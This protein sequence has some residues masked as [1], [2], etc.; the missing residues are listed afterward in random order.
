MSDSGTEQIK[1]I[2]FKWSGVNSEGKTESGEINAP[3]K[4]AALLMVAKK[5]KN[6]IK[7]KVNNSSSLF[8][9]KIQDKDINIFFRQL[10][11][12]ISTGLPLIQCLEMA[13]AGSE[14][15]TFKD[16]LNKLRKDIESGQPF[17]ETLGKQ[18]E[19]FD[20]LTCALITAGE[21]GGI[22][23]R[24]LVRIADYKERAA[25]LKGKIKSAMIYPS[26]IIATAFAVTSILMI[27]V[28]PVFGKMFSGAGRK[29]PALTQITIDASG[30]FVEYWYVI[31]FG[32]VLLLFLIRSWYKTNRGKHV[33]DAL[34]LKIPVLG[35]VLRKA[36]VARFCRTFATLISAGVP[37]LDAL[38]PVA[39]T[40]GNVII[41]DVLRDSKKTIMEGRNLTDP[42]TESGLFPVMVTQMIDIGEQ[43]GSLEETLSKV[44]DF[45]DQEVSQA[46]D[47][48]TALMEPLIMVVLGTLIGGLVISMY[49]PIFKMAAVMG[50]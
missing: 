7:I 25:I 42:L 4:E 18:P 37:I 29:L 24:I 34:I 49:L 14:N 16:I 11:T 39:E 27:F 10:A 41:E 2:S 20:R 19:Q 44:A 17:A 35:P 40:S 26:A 28:I 22:L 36:A 48:M 9:Q 13:E 38:D 43:T 30:L 33:L 3:S 5:G 8:K 21:Q 32:P 46:V 6:N 12:M 50:G 1:D 47:N 45:Y 15:K 31:V 23:D